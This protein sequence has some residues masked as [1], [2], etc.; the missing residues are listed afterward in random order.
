MFVENITAQHHVKHPSLQ[1]KGF[2]L[3]ASVL[4]GL[5]VEGQLYPFS[6]SQT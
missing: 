1:A 4:L 3:Q 5:L 2:R 6:T